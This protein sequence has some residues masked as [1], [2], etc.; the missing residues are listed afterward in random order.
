MA[1]APQPA[2]IEPP[3][4]EGEPSR[5]P[6]LHHLVAALLFAVA[7]FFTL[8]FLVTNDRLF[9]VFG[10]LFGAY[11]WGDGPWLW[12][13]HAY[14]LGAL[15]VLVILG[16]FFVETLEVYLPEPPLAA[17]SFILGAGLA[18]FLFELLAMAGLLAR[19]WVFIVPGLAILALWPLTVLAT[20]RRPETGE[21]GAGGRVEQAMRREYARERLRG[22]LIH[23]VGAGPR[24]FQA[25]AFGLLAAL[26]LLSFYHAVL[27]PEVYWDSLILY[28]GYAR[29]M[30]LERGIV[31][32]VVAQVGIGLG[33]NYPHL[34]ALLGAAAAAAADHWTELPQRWIAPACGLASTILVYYTVRQLTRHVNFSLAVTLLYRATPLGMAYDQYASDYAVA[35]ALTAAF[36]YLAL[37]Y[38]ETGLRG[39]FILA[40][41]LVALAMHLNYLMGLLWLP[42]G[43]M[44]LAAHVGLPTPEDEETEAAAR[45]YRQAAQTPRHELDREF[46]AFPEAPWTYHRRR[47]GLGAFLRSRTFGLTLIACLAVASTWHVR[48]WVVTGNPVYAFFPRIFGGRNINPEVLAS[49]EEEW[50]RNG[51]GIGS[52]AGDLP[53]RV[54]ASW[55][56]FVGVG[57][58]EAGAIRFPAAWRLQPFFPTFVL[59]GALI[60]LARLAAAPWTYRALARGRV[61]FFDPALR[62]GALSVL[63]A[64]A[65]L[66]Y[67]YVLA[68]FYLYQII[69]I[70]PAFAVLASYA[71][72]YWRLKGWRS[73]WGGLALVVGV[74]PGLAMGLMGFKVFSVP[75]GP[76]RRE[77]A[78][79]L[80]VFRNPNPDRERFYRW[81]FGDDA[82]MWSYINERLQGEKILTHEN[83]HLVFDPSITLVH[84]DDWAMQQ[85]WDQPAR[86][87]VRFLKELGVRYYL[88]V[89]NEVNH[90][91]NARMGTPEWERL[92]LMRPEAA[93]DGNV[94]FRL[95]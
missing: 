68:P 12:I 75:V 7:L 59:A 8:W 10:Q 89:P 77:P 67:H 88:R 40:T 15:F 23:P 95:E 2:A 93:F 48:N 92:G 83:R 72:P 45:A 94:L 63:F 60:F 44:I 64:A 73:A 33:A 82:V 53:G 61:A 14:S 13:D 24:L 56:Y 16:W 20:R 74:I 36:L 47:P 66:A 84:L 38:V 79:D 52:L 5:G 58:D 69:M 70:L 30:F 49:A 31:E 50:T 62:F 90:P 78:I 87:K 25:V 17:V 1:T 4:S 46:G 76:E 26:T 51:A 9:G 43:G 37:L 11:A 19:P 18:G 32:K 22:T 29:M 71:Y 39:Y 6:W 86:E 55:L 91:I 80:T 21:G 65:L 34:Y 54:R 42:W 57:R 41:L 27:Y 35:L 28:L 85:L 81:R 3:S